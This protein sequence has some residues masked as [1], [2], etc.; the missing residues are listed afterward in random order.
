MSAY[1]AALFMTARDALPTN[2]IAER[3]DLTVL[4]VDL[5]IVDMRRKPSEWFGQ[6][7]NFI[8][9]VP[10]TQ[11]GIQIDFHRILVRLGLI[12]LPA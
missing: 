12:L 8:H 7:V 1:P 6:I 4:P 2:S 10:F 9:E 5:G 11:I 3:R